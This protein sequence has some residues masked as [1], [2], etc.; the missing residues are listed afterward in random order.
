MRGGS[1][2]EEEELW[3]LRWRREKGQWGRSDKGVERQ[4]S[5]ADL[6]PLSFSHPDLA[7]LYGLLARIP[8]GLEPLRKRFEEHVRRQG[9]SAVEK[10]TAAKSAPGAGGDEDDAAEGDEGA[11]KTGAKEGKGE[12]VAPK[13]YIEALLEVHKRNLEVVN[14]SFRGEAGFVASL[15]KVRF[16]FPLPPSL[17]AC[18]HYLTISLSAG[19]SHRP[20]RTTST[21]TRRPR[22]RPATSRPTRAPSF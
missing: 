16:I 3:A 6:P 1:G 22:T 10:L 9:L 12:A 14:V 11:A 7:K 19:E 21:R 8:E 5:L 20:A 2:S 13:A 17:Q 15:D 18:V 4:L